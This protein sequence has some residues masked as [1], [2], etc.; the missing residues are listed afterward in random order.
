MNVTKFEVG[1]PDGDGDMWVNCEV[2]VDNTTK[3]DI[4]MIRTSTVYMNK[5]GSIFDCNTNN[6]LDTYLEP[7]ENLE[8]DPGTGYVKSLYCGDARDDIRLRVFAT[9]YSREFSKLGEIEVPS[10]PKQ[11]TTLHKTVTSSIIDPEI[12]TIISCSEPDDDGDIGI[13]IRCGILNKSDKHIDKILLKTELLD[14]KGDVIGTDESQAELAS[15]A[16][17][18]INGSIW[19]F[20]KGRLKEAQCR[21]SLSVFI[22]VH[23]ETCEALSTP[24]DR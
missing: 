9:F 7:G 18:C 11:Y 2:I 14:R 20:K 5:D 3:E 17:T 19:S 12:T 23:Q 1:Y 8:F 16:A 22:P 13:E 15:H 21:C 24:S 6:D 10:S 4:S